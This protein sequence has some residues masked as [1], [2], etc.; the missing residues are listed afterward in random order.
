MNSILN[1]VK[2]ALGLSENYNVFDADVIMHINSTF[3][4]LTQLGVGPVEGFR[5][6]DDSE[7]W[8]DFIG[9]SQHLESVKTYMYLKVRLLFDPPGTSFAI[10]SMKEM[11]REY[12][13]RLNVQAEGAF[14]GVESVTP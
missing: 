9:T 7:E 4:T 13:W 3:M 12:E 2:H 14:N 1:S 11:A 10:E 8:Q 5:I 6:L